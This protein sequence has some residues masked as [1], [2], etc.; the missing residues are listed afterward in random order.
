VSWD[1]SSGVEYNDKWF[2]FYVL[3]KLY[4]LILS[5]RFV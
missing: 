4:I 5:L 3:F 1:K 2:L